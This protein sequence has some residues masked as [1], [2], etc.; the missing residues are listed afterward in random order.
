MTDPNPLVSGKGTGHLDSKGIKVYVGEYEQEAKEPS[1][2]ARPEPPRYDAH[3]RHRQKEA[4]DTEQENSKDRKRD[5]GLYN[6]ALFLNLLRQE[7]Q[8]RAN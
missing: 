5:G 6:L 8:A 4:R 7:C 1:I 2:W 3:Q